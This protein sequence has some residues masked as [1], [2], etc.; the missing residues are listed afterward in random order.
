VIT[1]YVIADTTHV[2]TFDHQRFWVVRP[3]RCAAFELMRAL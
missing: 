1:Q 3:A 2:A